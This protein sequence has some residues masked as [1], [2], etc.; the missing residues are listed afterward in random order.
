MA[1]ASLSKLAGLALGL[2]VS[3]LVLKLKHRGP[4]AGAAKVRLQ[5]LAWV[6]LFLLVA[7][8]IPG[9]SILIVVVGIT[10]III[11]SDLERRFRKS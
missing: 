10:V 8:S 7:V 5:E 2:L 11:I 3:L 1:G 6:E 4:L 9:N